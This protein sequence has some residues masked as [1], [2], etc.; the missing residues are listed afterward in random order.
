MKALSRQ[1][2]LDIVAAASMLDERLNTGLLVD[3]ARTTDEMVHARLETWCQTV[4][5]GDWELFRQRLNRDGLNEKS[6]RSMLSL[7][8]IPEDA[9]LPAWTETL[10]EMVDIAAVMRVGEAGM[11]RDGVPPI[12]FLDTKEPF[13]FEE[14]LVPFVLLAQNR[15]TVKESNASDLLSEWAHAALFRG[16]LRTLTSYASQTLY[17]EFSIER[18]KAQSALHRLFAELQTGDVEQTFY[19]QFVGRMLQ[20]GLVNFFREY[21]VLARLLAT[22]TDLWVEATLEFL[23]RLAA[24]WSDL[25]RAFG[26]HGDVD[27]V[28]NV[29]SSLSNPYRGRRRVMVLTFTSGFKLVYKP[30]D[31]GI[32][33]AYYRLL[34]WCNAARMSIRWPGVLLRKKRLQRP[35]APALER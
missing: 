31:L 25:Q 33:E 16:L 34:N 12:P 10:R 13:P 11:H 27:R 17:L 24:D 4:A 29:E 5:R 22:I 30:K 26:V 28:T 8:K 35:S 1:A 21:S 9:P 6:V 3:D 20:D 7:V 32:E 15:C 19:Q 14:I 18:T 2:L 23:Q